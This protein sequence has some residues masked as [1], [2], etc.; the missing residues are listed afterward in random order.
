MHTRG[1]VGAEGSHWADQDITVLQLDDDGAFLALAADRLEAESDR[2]G[3]LSTTDPETALE[4]VE[5]GDVDCVVSDYQMPGMDGLEFLEAVRERYPDLPF[6]LFTGRGSEEI[7]GRA[8]SA[9]VTDYLQ[10]GT[11]NEQFTVLAN[12]VENTVSQRRAERRAREVHERITDAVVALDDEWRYT[13]M[14]ERA[15]DLVDR[16]AESLLGER[17]WDLFPFLEGTALGTGMREAMERQEPTTVEAHLEAVDRW[18]EFRTYP[19]ENGVSVYFRDVTDRRERERDLRQERA[20]TDALLEGLPDVLYAFDHSGTLL[21]WNDRLEAVTGYDATEIDAMGPLEF[22][23]PNERSVVA[24]AIETV[25]EE[26]RAT[27][28]ESELLTAD[29]ERIPYEFTGALLTDAAG[30]PVGLV[31][32]GRDLSDRRERERRFEAI[33]DNTYQFTGLATPDG[34]LLEA[35][36]TAL[37]FGGFE[38]ETVVG[39]PMWAAPWFSEIPA[40][41]DRAREAVQRAAEGQFVRDELEVQGAED[42]AI[43]DFSARPLYDADGEVDLLVLEGRDISELKAR[44]RELRRQNERLE[45]F[46]GVLSHGLRNRLGAAEGHLVLAREDPNEES[47]GQAQSA[48]ER[49]GDL[50]EDVLALAADGRVVDDPESVTARAVLRRAVE[51]VH[52][53]GAE[54]TVDCPAGRTVLAD[55][56]RLSELV[57]NLVANA[58]EH[59]ATST[60][61]DGEADPVPTVRVALEGDRLVVEDDGPGVPP[62]RR[63]EVFEAGHTTSVSGTGF[64]LAI[65]QQIAEAHGWTVGV[66]GSSLGGARFVVSGIESA[67]G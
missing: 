62:E 8:I 27:T 18:Y 6:V 31:G 36:E 35:N 9:G 64:G 25:F 20:F 45:E 4:H 52:T 21:R 39:E 59:G 10:K 41:R 13:Y 53:D 32:V 5:T 16:A 61:A 24:E 56:E 7:A 17:I 11:S 46:A 30:D 34:T 51:S 50:I 55:P 58:V 38:R 33:F 65:V 37:E 60:A 1:A 12:R 47:I 26:G 15:E 44:E 49:M 57:E 48:V 22:V 43:V 66:E 54:V 63:R 19:D 3:V 14:N 2:L 23:S 29:G 40:T 67:D 28:V 42:R